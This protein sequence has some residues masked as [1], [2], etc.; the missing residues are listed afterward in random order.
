MFFDCSSLEVLNLGSGIRVKNDDNEDT[1]IVSCALCDLFNWDI[2]R[3][4]TCTRE[5][6]TAFEQ[7]RSNNWSEYPQHNSWIDATTGEPMMPDE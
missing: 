3:T 6:M 1:G 7:E 2:E 4:I 5:I